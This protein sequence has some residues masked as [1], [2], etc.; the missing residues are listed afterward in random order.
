MS[1]DSS[2]GTGYSFRN[3]HR[4]CTRYGASSGP[5]SSPGY[6]YSYGASNGNSYGSGFGH[7]YSRS[8]SAGYGLS[9]GSSRR[10]RHRSHP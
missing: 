8:N 2:Y 9:Q 1:Y 3:G 5:D 7:S 4:S 6:G 10:T